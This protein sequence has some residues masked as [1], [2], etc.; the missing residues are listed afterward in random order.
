MTDD[1]GKDEKAR[2]DA[3]RIEIKLPDDM[4]GGV[5]ANNMVVTHTREE[6]VLDFLA[7]FHPKAGVVASRVVLS[8]GHLKRVVRALSENLAR[9]EAQHGVLQEAKSPDAGRVH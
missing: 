4:A 9:Y 8:P 1:T 2:N 3:G 7:V 6:F 5:Y